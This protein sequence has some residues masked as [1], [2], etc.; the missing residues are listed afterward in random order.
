[1]SG[2]WEEI[3]AGREP[4]RGHRRAVAVVLALAVGTAVLG[5]WLWHRSGAP[6]GPDALHVRL[7]PSEYLLTGHI[8]GRGQ[9]EVLLLLRIDVATGSTEPVR[10]L[11]MRGGGITVDSGHAVVGRSARFAVPARVSCDQWADGKGVEAVFAVG[12]GRGTEVTVP[13]DAGPSAPVRAQISAPCTQ[14]AS[15]HPLRLTRFD[16][17]QPQRGPAV[18]TTWTV[19]NRS[20][21]PVT[22]SPGTDL[23]VGG[24][25]GNPLVPVGADSSGPTVVPA[26]STLSVVRRVEVTS[27]PRA[28]ALDPSGVVVELTGVW[29][30]SLAQRGTVVV[31]LPEELVHQLV[32]VVAVVCRGIT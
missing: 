2:A 29:D 15:T 5:Q 27:C 7:D 13:L 19:A 17:T 30:A 9:A 32:T 23:I 21:T 24:A 10:L 16:V 20:D 14:F 18:L 6:P 26:G 4:E 25:P 8:D 28:A 3:R 11:R 22:L 1:M 31:E 12:P